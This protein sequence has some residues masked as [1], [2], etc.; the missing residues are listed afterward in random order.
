MGFDENIILC[1]HFNIDEAYIGQKFCCANKWVHVKGNF[2]EALVFL[3]KVTSSQLCNN[4]Y[5]I[6]TKLLTG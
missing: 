5:Y 6:I 1:G 2:D 4:L 3:Q